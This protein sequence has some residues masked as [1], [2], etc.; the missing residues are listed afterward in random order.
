MIGIVLPYLM[1]EI[2]HEHQR[3]SVYLKNIEA[4]AALCDLEFR[5][6][7]IGPAHTDR[8]SI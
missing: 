5:H 2:L 7:L 3:M 8:T 1:R 4:V 6:V